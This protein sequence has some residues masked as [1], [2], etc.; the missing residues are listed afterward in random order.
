MLC[1]N[2][3]SRMKWVQ[4]LKHKSEALDMFKVFKNQVENQI[5]GRIKCLRSNRG[6]EFTSEDFT[7]YYEKHGIRRQLSAART[8]QQNGVVERKNRTM[9]EMIRTMLIESKVVDRFWKETI[10]TTIYIQN[11]CMLRPNE[12]KTPYEMW[13]DRR[14]TIRH[15]KVFGSKCYIKRT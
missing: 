11:R 12:N 3:Y 5:G 9:Q 15:F 6:G 1:I 4:F 8:P 7:K 10:H 14:A 2:D 13:F